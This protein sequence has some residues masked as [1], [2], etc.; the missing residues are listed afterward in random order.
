MS[1]FKIFTLI[2]IFPLISSA[3][4]S[5]RLSYDVTKVDVNLSDDIAISVIMESSAH[6]EVHNGFL[7]YRVDSVHLG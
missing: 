4:P 3:Q 7:L 1:H 2:W 5:L 6:V